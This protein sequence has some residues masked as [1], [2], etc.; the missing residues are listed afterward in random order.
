ML[1]LEVMCVA[2]N[3]NNCPITDLRSDPRPMSTVITVYLS[4]DRHREIHHELVS[5]CLKSVKRRKYYTK[6]ISVICL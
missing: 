6:D 4:I 3:Q 5:Q 2:E 1:V